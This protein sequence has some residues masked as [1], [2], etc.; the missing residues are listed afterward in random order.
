MC[1]VI[2]IPAI[3]P[4]GMG[5]TMKQIKAD[6]M[7]PVPIC[8]ITRKGTKPQGYKA[9]EAFLLNDGLMKGF[10]AFNK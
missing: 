6:D 5:L 2:A 3:V 8:L 10:S 7:L 1:L 9:V 4:N